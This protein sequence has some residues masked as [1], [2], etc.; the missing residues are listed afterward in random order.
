VDFKKMEFLQRSHLKQVIEEEPPN[1]PFLAAEVFVPVESVIRSFNGSDAAH[2]LVDGLVPTFS[3]LLS[4]KPTA[5]QMQKGHAHLRAA[6]QISKTPY[7][8]LEE[9][10]TAPANMYLFWR[11]PSQVLRDTFRQLIPYRTIFID[12]EANP[13]S[14]A[15]NL[16]MQRLEALDAKAWS[17]E[18]TQ[19]ADMLQNTAR[20]ITC[21]D[22]NA[23][24]SSIGWKFLRW[25][26]LAADSGP[27][28]IGAVKVLGKDETLRRLQLAKDIASDIQTETEAT[29]D[30]ESNA[31]QAS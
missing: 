22:E 3:Y 20:E 31:D 23:Q 19:M 26:L 12:D 29:P 14:E 25:A 7:R 16:Y 24:S 13:A 28:V 5:E 27:K 21:R 9:W 30:A 17:N 11:I 1:W 2:T 18:D 10:V 15:I 8:K 4:D 6:M